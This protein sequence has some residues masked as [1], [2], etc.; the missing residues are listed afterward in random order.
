ME[1]ELFPAGTASRLQWGYLMKIQLLILIAF[2]AGQALAY[3]TIR[4][5]VPTQSHEA[6]WRDAL[7]VKLDGVTEYRVQ[8][9]RVDVL[10]ADLAIELDYPHKYHESI[11][12]ALH[13]A[14]ETGKIGVVALIFDGRDEMDSAELIWLETLCN[15][16]NV[17]LI[18]LVREAK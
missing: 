10:T 15:K 13:Y 1:N 11:G 6:Q 5:A 16:Y 2:L 3:D 17:R 9:G 4:L 14:S 18:V 7:A 8:Y 12:Q